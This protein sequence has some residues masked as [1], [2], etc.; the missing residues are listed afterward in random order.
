MIDKNNQFGEILERGQSSIQQAGQAIK[1][2]VSDIVKSGA[3]QIG[4]EDKKPEEPKKKAIDDKQFVMDLLGIKEAK[5]PN[6]IQDQNDPEKPLDEKQVEE[7]SKIEQLRKSL[8]AEYYQSIS[9]PSRAEERV[10]DK[11]DREER[12]EK[13]KKMEDI[14]EQEKKAPVSVHQA[15]T[16]VEIKGGVGG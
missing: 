10:A 9:T 11:V 2:Q 1:G 7:K 4:R 8:H 13:A 3:Q 12:E 16:K 15:Q 6:E 5:K 14:K